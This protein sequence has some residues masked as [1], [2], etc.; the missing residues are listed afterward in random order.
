MEYFV[1]IHIHKKFLFHIMCQVKNGNLLK[2]RVSEICVKRIHV[3][4]EVVVIV[5]VS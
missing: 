4:Q 5:R 2:S 3:N 1:K